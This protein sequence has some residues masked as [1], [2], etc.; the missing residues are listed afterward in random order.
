MIPILK[1]AW[2]L[3]L[4]PLDEQIFQPLLLDIFVDSS[5]FDSDTASDIDFQCNRD[6]GA[7][8]LFNQSEHYDLIKHLGLYKGFAKC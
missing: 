8:Q 6:I 7:H 1:S 4:A 2:L 3:S 5:D